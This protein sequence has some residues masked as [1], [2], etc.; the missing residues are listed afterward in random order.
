MWPDRAACRMVAAG[1]PREGDQP[2]SPA[3]QATTRPLEG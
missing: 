3:H 1:L 2:V